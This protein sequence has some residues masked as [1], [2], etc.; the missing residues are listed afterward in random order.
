MSNEAQRIRELETEVETLKE[1]LKECVRVLRDIR[2]Y[3]WRNVMRDALENA[4]RVLR[5]YEG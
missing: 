1:S 4:E 5:K 3:I 2:H